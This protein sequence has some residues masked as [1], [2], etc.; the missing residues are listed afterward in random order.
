MTDFN[1][2][3]LILDPENEQ[4]VIQGA[5]DAIRVASDNTITDFN[6]SSPV[7]ALIEGQAF[8]YMELL[9]YLNQLPTA[10]A[11]E[12]FRLLGISRSPGQ[13]AKGEVTFVLSALL[14]TDFV[15]SAGYFIPYK[16][17]GF[18]TS[19][20]LV[21]P[22]GSIEGTVQ[23]QATREGSDMNLPAFGLTSTGLSLTYLQS[24]YNSDP[25]NGG[26]DL[27]PLTATVDR[28][29]IEIRSR[30]TL[31]SQEDYEQVAAFLLGDGSTA[32]AFPLMTSDKETEALGHIHVFLLDASNMQPSIAACQSIQAQLKERSFAG[33]AVW[34]SPANVQ[35]YNMEVIIEVD[36]IDEAI[37]DTIE[38][39]ILDYLHPA[40][41]KLGDTLKIK[42]LE[43]VVRQQEKV[44]AVVTMSIDNETTNKPMPSKYTQP[45]LN[46]LTVILNDSIGTTATYY[47]SQILDF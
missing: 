37:A 42:E 18:V 17:A 5:Y 43:Y 47:R 23:V 19:A 26:S 11:L 35:T 10:L 9:W 44:N 29:Q 1:I 15:V 20:T 3:K 2:P 7:A 41:F 32:T 27:E 8:V 6:P 22:A 33:A 31:I 28:A 14:A 24:I 45:K 30:G 12:V 21:I 38:S 36:N 34:V 39:A 16:D 46:T 13:T 4:E 25:I 40:N